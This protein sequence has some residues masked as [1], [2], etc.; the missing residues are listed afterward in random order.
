MVNINLRLALSPE[1]K[2]SLLDPLD[3]C[4]PS[5]FGEDST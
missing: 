3:L 1:H 5:T 4:F 2:V